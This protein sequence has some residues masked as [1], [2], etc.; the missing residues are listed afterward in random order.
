MSR[1]ERFFANLRRN[2][3]DLLSPMREARFYMQVI[4]SF[5]KF[6]IRSGSCRVRLSSVWGVCLFR[7]Q[8]T[9]EE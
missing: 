9:Q 6:L 8:F 5:F 2:E 3:S 1:N 4:L 7:L